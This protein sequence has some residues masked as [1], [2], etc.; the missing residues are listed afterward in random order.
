LS[1]ATFEIG[2]LRLDKPEYNDTD[3]IDV[4]IDVKNT[5]T[6]TGSEVVQLYFNQINASVKTPLKKLIRFERIQ[7]EPGQTKTVSFSIPVKEM[8]FWDIKNNDIIVESG[9]FTIMAGSSSQDIHQT[10]T[11]NVNGKNMNRVSSVLMPEEIIM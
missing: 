10:A 2:S 5:G 8:G 9:Q 7:L 6:M 4:S 11:I 1:Y 3:K